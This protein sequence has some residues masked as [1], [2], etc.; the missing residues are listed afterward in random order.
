M[1][2]FRDIK[3][4]AF[5][6]DTPIKTVIDG[7]NID[8]KIY[9]FMTLAVYGRELVGRDIETTDFRKIQTGTGTRTYKN[10][11]TSTAG[12]ENRFLSSTISAR[13]ITVKYA[14]KAANEYDYFRKFELLNYYLGAENCKIQFTDDLRYYYIGTVSKVEN[15]QINGLQVIGT[16]SIEISNPFKQRVDNEEFTFE[17]EGQFKK[18]TLY[19]VKI[20]NIKIKIKEPGSKFIFKNLSNGQRIIFD[21]DF[22]ADDVINIDFVENLI[23]GKGGQSLFKYLDITS[24]LEEFT[25]GNNDILQSS[26]NADITVIFRE[27][28]L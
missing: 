16:F 6:F 5:P 10:T 15:P 26:L 12:Y 13:E 14:L 18:D 7:I 27:V 4:Y 19:P 24:D 17:K 20:E 22:K 8:D 3:E 9:G 21:K 2:D 23:T 1:Y 25:I 11:K 28:A